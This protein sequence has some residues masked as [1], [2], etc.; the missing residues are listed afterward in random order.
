MP[1]EIVYCSVKSVI[2]W[3][4]ANEIDPIDVP[5]DSSLTIDEDPVQGFRIIRYTAL[6]RNELGH[7]VIDKV[8]GQPA[9][10][11]RSARLLV[12]PNGDVQIKGPRQ[13]HRPDDGDLENVA[14][15]VTAAQQALQSARR[16]LSVAIHAARHAGR[17][18]Q[19]IAA[20]TGLDPFTVRNI[21]AVTPARAPERPSDLPR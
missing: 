4:K 3:L 20:C 11:G 7:I 14:A 18:V 17:S 13:R 16:D 2:E 19:H 9:V 5:A 10:C 15:A 1:E 8:T 21:L 6:L 12:E